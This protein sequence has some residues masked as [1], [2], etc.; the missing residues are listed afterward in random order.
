[1]QTIY[2]MFLSN[3]KSDLKSI[4]LFYKAN[5]LVKD[6]RLSFS[7]ELI[8][9]QYKK[10]LASLSIDTSDSGVKAM[11]QQRMQNDNVTAV[12]GMPLHIFLVGTYYDHEAL[13][14]L[15][16]LQ[17]LGSVSIYSNVLGG[18]GINLPQGRTTDDAIQNNGR[19]LVQS[20]REQHRSNP[21]DFVIG[22]FTASS[23]PVDALRAIRVM[24]IPVVNYAMDDRLPVH[25]RMRKGVRMGAIGLV[26]GVDLTLQTT[27]EYIPRYLAEGCPAIYFPFGSDPN[28]FKPAEQKKLDVV[29]VGNNYGKRGKLIAAI[30]SAGIRV[31]AYGL[32]FPN[33][34]L[35]GERVPELFAHAKIILGTGLVGH[36]SHIMTIKLRDFDGPMSGALYITND[37][38][39]LK[40]HFEIGKEILVYK[41]INDCVQKIK[42]YLDDNDAR[43]RIAAAAR[44]R[45]IADHTWDYRFAT[46]LKFLSAP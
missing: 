36:S 34:H 40:E 24:G 32:G 38:P 27:K 3:L 31:D 46:M 25:W 33:G 45:A 37:N 17:K 26:D 22:T 4:P 14:F 21:I 1:M 43:E 8:R 5:S 41:T 39:D 42:N 15:Q 30:Q 23:I 2:N 9:R 35:A 19:H 12:R 11:L 10:R 16:G 7:T 28:I 13:G 20:V 18:Y 6:L 29:F 44:Q